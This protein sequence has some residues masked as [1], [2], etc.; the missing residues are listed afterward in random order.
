MALR[1]EPGIGTE[2]LNKALFFLTIG[3]KEKPRNSAAFVHG[4]GSAQ[5][6]PS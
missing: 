1:G 2:Y 4:P 3:K 6:L 5:L